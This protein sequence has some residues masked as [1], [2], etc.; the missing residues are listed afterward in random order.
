MKNQRL[1][2]VPKDHF[3]KGWNYNGNSDRE[4]LCD[5]DPVEWEC[6]A[7][8]VAWG[9]GTTAVKMRKVAYY[10]SPKHGYDYL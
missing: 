10:S 8:H 2:N 9:P 6:S 7:T 4:Q 3:H 1:L 5:D